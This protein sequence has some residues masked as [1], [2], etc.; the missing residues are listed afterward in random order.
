MSPRYYWFNLLPFKSPLKISDI[1]HI[2]WHITV[3]FFTIFL[4]ACNL[5]CIN[6]R[7]RLPH[8]HTHLALE[9]TRGLRRYFQRYGKPV[10][11][12]RLAA[13]GHYYYRCLSLYISRQCMY[14]YC[15]CWDVF[16]VLWCSMCWFTYTHINMVVL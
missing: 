3:W 16:N 9:Q 4:H 12:N 8:S 7:S 13:N 10:N 5:G 15:V 2:T 6:S 11:G 1:S 14:V